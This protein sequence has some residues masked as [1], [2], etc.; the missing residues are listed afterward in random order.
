MER[1]QMKLCTEVYHK[2]FLNDYEEIQQKFITLCEPIIK[3][4]NCN[5]K[6]EKKESDIYKSISLK[7]N[8][9]KSYELT[10]YEDYIHM[11]YFKNIAVSEKPVYLYSYTLDKEEGI[12]KEVFVLEDTRD[13]NRSSVDFSKD[14][15]KDFDFEIDYI[16]VINTLMNLIIT[17]EE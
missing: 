5:I 15:K 12:V 1:W 10:I 13:S 14:I 6:I 11:A 7:I 8:Y 17:G 16:K 3:N 9:S 4:S 2:N